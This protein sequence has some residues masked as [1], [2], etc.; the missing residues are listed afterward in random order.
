MY[1]IQNHVLHTAFSTSQSFDHVLLENLCG[2]EILSTVG[3]A[4]LNSFADFVLDW[5]SSVWFK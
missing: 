4:Q 2:I 3:M 1:M 5:I